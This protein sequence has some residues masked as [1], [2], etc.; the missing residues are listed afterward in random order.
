MDSSPGNPHVLYRFFSATGQLLYVGIT[1]NPPQRFKAHGKS[2]E[3][4]DQVRGITVETYPS[5]EHLLRAE[6]RAIQVERPFHNVTHNR[7]T[8]TRTKESPSRTVHFFCDECGSSAYG[9][10]SY[11]CVSHKEIVA[12]RTAW[13]DFNAKS[14]A[15]VASGDP[16]SDV[17]WID[18]CPKV[19]VPQWRTYHDE[20]NPE[21]E[22]VFH[23]C[24]LDQMQ[25]EADLIGYTAYLMSNGW[26]RFTNWPEFVQAYCSDR[27]AA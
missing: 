3:W 10:D 27:W 15:R 23:T 5:R 1:M 21:P 25:N 4:W 16:L 12:Y 24:E 17:T 8:D 11:L 26:G 2:K 9:A 20:C 6:R 22:A 19:Q 13:T 14:A 18:D 7:K